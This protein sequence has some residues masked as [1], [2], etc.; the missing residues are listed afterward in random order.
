MVTLP[1]VYPIMNSY[2]YSPIWFGVII[3]KLMEI[4]VITPPFGLNLFTVVTAADGRVSSSELMAG[5]LP[6]VVIE[7]IMLTILIVFP[8]LSTWLPSTMY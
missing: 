8:A 1:F 5:V 6:F 3:T 7:L 4:A 2:G